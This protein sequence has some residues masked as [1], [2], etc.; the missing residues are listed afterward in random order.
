MKHASAKKALMIWGMGNPLHR[1]DGA[2]VR[3][4]EL[5]R[6]RLRE[7]TECEV[8]ICETQP[9]NFLGLLRKNPPEMLLICDASD[10]GLPPGSLR[11]FT[12]LE[13]A[14]ENWSTHG[15]PLERLLEPFLDSLSI[16]CLGIQ[17][18]CTELG[19]ELSP[20]V[21]R[22]VEELVSLIEGNRWYEIPLLS[23]EE[24]STS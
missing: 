1:D 12:P 23:K 9:E 6:E 13:M 3:A 22:G 16:F 20:S 19:T 15:Y 24:A 4:A 8:R 2:G 21:A 14:Q 7:K 18:E 17:P 5:L 10:M 11:R